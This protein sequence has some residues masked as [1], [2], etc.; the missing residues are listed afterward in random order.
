MIAVHVA[1]EG[2]EFGAKHTLQRHRRRLDHGHLTAALTRGSSELDSDPP[3]ADHHDP[4][5]GLQ[6][7]AQHVAIG[8]RTQVANPVQIGSWDRDLARLGAGG[9][10][11]PIESE[12]GAVTERDLRAHGVDRRDRRLAHQFDAMLVVIALR[13][14][15]G[16]LAR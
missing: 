6:I 12:L 16:L 7:P 9:Q 1:V 3:R 13:V 8:Q 14:D 5:A 15:V 11:Q 4:A 2:A 10:Q